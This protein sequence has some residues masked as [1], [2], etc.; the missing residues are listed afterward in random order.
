MYSGGT[1]QIMN[2]RATQKVRV[3]NPYYSNDNNMQ[4][5]SI[6]GFNTKLGTFYDHFPPRKQTDKFTRYNTASSSGPDEIDTSAIDNQRDKVRSSL[7]RDIVSNSQ[8]YGPY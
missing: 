1:N 5:S 7:S 4:Q 2:R 8:C 3:K 6:P